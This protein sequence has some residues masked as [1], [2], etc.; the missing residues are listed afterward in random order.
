MI[1]PSLVGRGDTVLRQ[2]FVQ[3]I[4]A[5]IAD[6]AQMGGHG[7]QQTRLPQLLDVV[8]GARCGV[9][10]G[11][12]E[13]IFIDDDRGFA[14]MLFLLPRVVLALCFIVLG[15]LN[16]LF[17]GIDNGKEVGMFGQRLL[18]APALTSA[19]WLRPLELGLTHLTQNLQDPTPIPAHVRLVQTKEVAHRFRG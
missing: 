18:C 15:S 8:D 11:A 4:I 2:V 3:T 14:C 10:D 7:L 1:A 16:R 5:R 17:R 9:R 19:W 13:A 12:D 6:D